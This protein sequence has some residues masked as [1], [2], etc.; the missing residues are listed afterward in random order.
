MPARRGRSKSRSRTRAPR[1]R[2]S[3]SNARPRAHERTQ[4]ANASMSN[5]RLT[6]LQGVADSAGIAYSGMT[7]AQ[8]LEAIRRF[9]QG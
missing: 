6:E 2:P 5:M 8:L 1:T 7:K 4:S 3:D 9:T